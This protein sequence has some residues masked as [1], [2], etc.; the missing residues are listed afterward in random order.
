M[1]YHHDRFPILPSTKL[2]LG[3]KLELCDAS[4]DAWIN[5][6]QSRR[7]NFTDHELGWIKLAWIGGFLAS[8]SEVEQWN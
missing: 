8:N 6:A 1:S 5:D 7:G 4:F 3:D 2:K